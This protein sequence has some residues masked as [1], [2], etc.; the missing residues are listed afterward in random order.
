MGKKQ[1]K[2]NH[3]GVPI[4]EPI[5]G[6]IYLPDFKVYTYGIETSE[7]GIEWMRYEE[8]CPLPE[9]V[10]T[11]PHI[12]FEVDNIH[13]TIKNKKVIIE[14]NSPSKGVIVAFIEENGFPIEFIQYV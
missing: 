5:E 4:K 6:E 14:P 11:M 3:L 7:Y 2:Y 12:A 1:L 10:K 13:E 8:D 9:I